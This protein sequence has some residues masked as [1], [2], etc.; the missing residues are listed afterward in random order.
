MKV[1]TDIAVRE[2]AA[3]IYAFLLR[4]HNGTMRALGARR[5]GAPVPIGRDDPGVARGAEGVARGSVADTHPSP[6]QACARLI[7]PCILPPFHL[8]LSASTYDASN[9]RQIDLLQTLQ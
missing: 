2:A 8:R 7:T 4:Y 3:A 1:R 5:E 6:R 9:V